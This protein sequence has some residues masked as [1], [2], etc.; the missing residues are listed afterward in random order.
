MSLC[1]GFLIAKL[2]YIVFGML[3]WSLRML[4]IDINRQTDKQTDILRERHGE[5]KLYRQTDRYRSR[6]AESQIDR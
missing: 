5:R 1:V 3:G 6:Q 4:I 2:F